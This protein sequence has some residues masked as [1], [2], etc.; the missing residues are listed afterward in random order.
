MPQGLKNYKMQIYYLF[1]E[2]LAEGLGG[3]SH[4]WEVVSR[5]NKTGYEVTVFAPRVGEFRPKNNL[6]I[7]YIPTLDI[8]LLRYVLFQFI[9]L[10][11]LL[12]Y[13]LIRKPD[14]IYNREM[15][16]SPIPIVISKIL[17][18][19]LIT[20]INGDLIEE[21]KNAGRSSLLI[22]L[23]GLIEKITCKFSNFIVCVTEGLKNII[24]ERY[25]ISEDGF[26]VVPNGTNPGIMRSLDQKECREKLGLPPEKR[27]VGFVGTF[28]S[29]QGLEHLVECA[30]LIVGKYP[31]LIFLIVGDGPMR[32][33]LEEQI[34][35][36]GL[37]SFFILPG[38]VSQEKVVYYI[39][40]MDICVAPFT[41]MRNE[42]IGLSSLKIYDY[43]A[44][45]KPI[46]A[47]DIPGV[48]E[49]LR[50]HNLGIPVPPDNTQELAN[51][52]ISILSSGEHI[53][54]YGQ[55]GRR[56]I[57]E[58]FDWEITA[59]KIKQICDKALERRGG[60]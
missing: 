57:L 25:L 1:Y 46:V 58:K 33:K 40:S 15:V 47:S 12:F 35:K 55:E 32:K 60:R 3:L 34:Q 49:L 52:I 50:E 7:K 48:G 27:Y 26:F 38:G 36:R 21:W 2:Y 59:K 4:V 54:K 42:R 37:S 13:S 9:S 43:M 31:E 41:R 39:N 18:V 56:V 6:R 14:L 19:P 22:W 20:E 51:A 17:Q 11:Y 8:H 16:L 53:S 28:T 23:V 45:N 10:F 5:L 29:H 44:C 24:S 30:K